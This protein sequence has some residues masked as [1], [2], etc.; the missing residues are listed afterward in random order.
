V[1]AGA[2]GGLSIGV[3]PLVPSPRPFPASPTSGFAHLHV[4][5]GFSFLEG[6]SSVE[7]LVLR[8]A[9]LGMPALG[10]PDTNSVT[11]VASLARR[12]A[13]AGIK[14]IGGCSVVLEGGCRLTLLADGPPGWASL[15]RLL[16]AAAL[17]DVGRAGPRARW[18][19]VEAHRAGLVCLSGAPGE[20][21]VPR[22]V[23]RT[24]LP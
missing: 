12:C 15:C 3:L 8:A 24:E 7:A 16:S 2:V 13:K 9:E 19:E 14:P 10:P 18:E 22:L 17:R 1:G 6:P 23:A 5:S 20:G 21:E 11:G 4:R